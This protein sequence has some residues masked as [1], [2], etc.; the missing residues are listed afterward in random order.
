MLGVE[1]DDERVLARCPVLRSIAVDAQL[2]YWGVLLFTKT[3]LP[4]RVML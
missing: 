2:S 1:H 4:S 3:I